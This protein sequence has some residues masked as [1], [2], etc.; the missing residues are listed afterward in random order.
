MGRPKGVPKTGGRK[1]GVPNK[2]TLKKAEEIA[3]SG[4]TPLEFML[5]IL[6]DNKQEVSARMEAAKAAA[7]YVHPRL[8]NV[9]VAGPDGGPLQVQVVSFARSKDT[10]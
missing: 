4:L 5:K 2:V 1:K 3:K 10:E 6:R 8:A 7:P 9:E